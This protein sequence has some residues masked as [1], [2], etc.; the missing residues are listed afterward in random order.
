MQGNGLITY[1]QHTIQV[2]SNTLMYMQ[3]QTDMAYRCKDE[4]WKFWWF[5]FFG[6]C[7]IAANQLVSFVPDQLMLLLMSNSLQYAKCADWNLAASLFQ[8]LNL[9]IGRNATGLELWS[10]QII[11]LLN[12]GFALLFLPAVYIIGKLKKTL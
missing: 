8:S 2:K 9:L 7:P 4:K 10:S 12:L 1:N 11:P 6:P 5:E 3:P